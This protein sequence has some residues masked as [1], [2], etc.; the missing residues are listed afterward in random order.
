MTESSD[1]PA[2][3][4][5]EL[6]IVV[7]KERICRKA[8][9]L[10]PC[11]GC[12]CAVRQLLEKHPL[13]D[14]RLLSAVMEEHRPAGGDSTH[15]RLRRAYLRDARK[16]K[17]LLQNF[18][19]DAVLK[20][21][22]PL[23]NGR[24][25]GFRGGDSSRCALHK[26]N[27][28]SLT[29]AAT[30]AAE[31]ARLSRDADDY[32]GSSYA[33]GQDR[34]SMK[35]AYAHSIESAVI[36]DRVGWDWEGAWKRLPEGVRA[37]VVCLSIPAL[38][39]AVQVMTA[40][41][42]FCVDCRHNV[43]TAFDILIGR[44]SLADVDHAGEFVPELYCPFSILV[45]DESSSDGSFKRS[46][47]YCDMP[48]DT[49]R[50]G[51]YRADPSLPAPFVGLEGGR[52]YENGM[53]DFGEGIDDLDEE[54]DVHI[55]DI[56]EI[57]MEA[58]RRQPSGCGAL[59]DL[60][61]CVPCESKVA[62]GAIESAP[63]YQCWRDRKLCV[64]EDAVE[65]MI[66]WYEDAAAQDCAFGGQRHAATLENAQCEVR[67]I[68]GAV[69]LQQLRHAWQTHMGRVQSEQFLFYLCIDAVRAD[70]TV[71][72]QSGEGDQYPVLHDLGLSTGP[73]LSS[74][75]GDGVDLPA[76]AE[77]LAVQEPQDAKGLSE[78]KISK[79][80]KKR[81]KRKERRRQHL[82]NVTAASNTLDCSAPKN[83]K[84]SGKTQKAPDKL[85]RENQEN[86]D[87]AFL[88]NGHAIA[89]LLEEAP[90]LMD[91]LDTEGMGADES[92]VDDDLIREME[93]LRKKPSLE[94]DKQRHRKELAL[95]FERWSKDQKPRAAV[96]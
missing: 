44:Q 26:R 17:P 33:Y 55:D 23:S 9:Q 3:G 36:E 2:A 6:E 68:V 71:R 14:I 63:S 49:F 30:L 38:E 41:H 50:P 39:S 53:G 18:Q 91:L 47:I 67:S 82:A 10:T 22:Q 7:S 90:S 69:L 1:Q 93:A 43:D 77:G 24:R 61:G 48:Y 62:T 42:R 45:E 65:E 72:L 51:S 15:L 27:A 74:S 94:N 13:E 70:L 5:K 32:S 19:M 79:S 60:H 8:S 25:K 89:N 16:L 40:K 57:E 21:V 64:D 56:D 11:A 84:A 95:K 73:Y 80:K 4:R 20:K 46:C 96:L 86:G 92:E 76:T 37:D 88:R 12:R 78:Q 58:T 59:D 87:Q 35:H 75:L 52:A 66:Y 83:R 85:A 34:Y 29:A 31:R 81:E 28:S 54:D